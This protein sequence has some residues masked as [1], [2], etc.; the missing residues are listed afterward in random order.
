MK[1]RVNLSTIPTRDLSL[2]QHSAGGYKRKP[3]SLNVFRRIPV[4]SQAAGC[5]F[6]DFWAV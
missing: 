6:D 3:L 1:T 5:A 4:V 2:R